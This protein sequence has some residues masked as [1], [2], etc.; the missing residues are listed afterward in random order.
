MNLPNQ[1][2][3]VEVTTPGGPDVLRANTVAV[4][5]PKEGEVLVKTIIT[6]AEG[7]GHTI[8]AEGVETPEQR[9]WLDD[10]GCH[11]HQG[12]LLGRPMPAEEIE[13]WDQRRELDGMIGQLRALASASLAERKPRTPTLALISNVG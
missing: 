5:A 9:A 11:V 13:G 2:I 1:M 7:L 10:R 12:F 6:M 3:G 8:V 4:P